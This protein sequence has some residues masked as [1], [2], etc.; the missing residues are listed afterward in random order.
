MGYYIEA[1]EVHGKVQWIVDNY[2]GKVVALPASYDAIPEG[3]GLIVVVDNGIFE[4]AGFAYSEEEFR[5]FSNISDYRPKTWL[6][7]DRAVAEVAT[8]YRRG[9][10]SLPYYRVLDPAAVK[11]EASR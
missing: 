5:V 11:E 10:G 7:I 6:L 3:K 1:P 4:A 9:P 2:D 8:G